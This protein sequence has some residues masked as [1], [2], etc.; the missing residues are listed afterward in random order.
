ML[1]QVVSE[2]NSTY[3][4]NFQILNGTIRKRKINKLHKH[5]ISKPIS[6][7]LNLTNGFWEFANYLLNICFSKPPLTDYNSIANLSPQKLVTFVS[8]NWLLK[9]WKMVGFQILI[10]YKSVYNVYYSLPVWEVLTQDPKDDNIDTSVETT[11]S[12]NIK[13]S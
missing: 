13:F 8:H 6:K 2:K 3:T 7:Q 1:F 5:L 11:I 10:I 4:L 9:T 12:F